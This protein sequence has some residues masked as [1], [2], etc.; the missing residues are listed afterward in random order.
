[1]EKITIDVPD[2]C[3]SYETPLNWMEAKAR[4]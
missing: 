3:D 2:G 4:K 1:M